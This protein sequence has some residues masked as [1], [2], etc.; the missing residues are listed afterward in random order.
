MSCQAPLSCIP[1]E[2]YFEFD[3][4]DPAGSAITVFVSRR[5]RGIHEHWEVLSEKTHAP[6]VHLALNWAHM[7]KRVEVFNNRYGWNVDVVARA[8]N[9]G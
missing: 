4:I 5:G 2:R 8:V 7:I 6:G 1:R 3:I 9:D